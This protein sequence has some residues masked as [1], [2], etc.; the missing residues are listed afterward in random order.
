MFKTSLTTTKSVTKVLKIL[1]Y[2]H[3]PQIPSNFLQDIFDLSLFPLLVKHWCWLVGDLCWI[4]RVLKNAEPVSEMC[5][6]SQ[7]K[8][9]LPFM[10]REYT[11]RTHKTH[12]QL[13]FAV[14]KPKGKTLGCIKLLPFTFSRNFFPA[15]SAFLNNSHFQ[16]KSLS[17][18]TL[19]A[20]SAPG[21]FTLMT[22]VNSISAW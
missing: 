8:P 2:Y 9:W 12:T 5:E 3:P 1:Y 6:D 10:L 19:N 4:S 20:L 16:N 14:V 13:T 11:Y 21:E 15:P 18:S 7:W 17:Y 22:H